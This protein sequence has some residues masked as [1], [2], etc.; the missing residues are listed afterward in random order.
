MSRNA[1]S[2]AVVAVALVC[3]AAAQSA[4]EPARGSGIV[5]GRVVD[6]NGAPVPAA[7]VSLEKASGGDEEEGDRVLTDDS[8]RFVFSNVPAGNFRIDARKAGWLAGSLGRKRPGGSR[9]SFDLSDGERRN[10][11]AITLWRSAII[12]GRVVDDAGDPL[13]G[14]EVRAIKQVFVAGR[15]QNDKPIRE[16]TDDRGVYRFPNLVPGDYLVA[17]IASVLSEPPGLAGAVHAG[18]ELP[19]SYLETMAATGSYPV[20]FDRATGLVG[21]DRA[22]VGSLTS[23]P[24]MPS[25]DGAWPAYPTTYHPGATAQAGATLIRAQSGE[26]RTD[27][28]VTVRLTPTWPV[29]GIVRDAA[30]PAVFHAVHLVPADTSDRPL[31]DVATAVTD[32]KGA[33][34]LYGVPA[35]RYIARVIRV[36]VPTGSRYGLVGGTGEIPQV[37]AF[38]EGPPG[39][40]GPPTESLWHADQSVVVV[41]RAIRDVA[42]TMREGARVRGR[43]RFEGSRAQPTAEEWQKARLSLLPANGRVDAVPWNAPFMNDGRF[44]SAS[45]WPGR[46]LV[47]ADAPPG[48]Y[49]K[50][51]TYQGREISARP[52]DVA[53][54]LDNVVITFTDKQ[55]TMKGSVQVEPGASSEDATVLLFPV[56]SALWIDSGRPSRLMASARV[57]KSA[58]YELKLPPPGEY[59]IVAIPEEAA[60]EWQNPA[61]LSKL[62]T[63]A[64]RIRVTG[65]APMVQSLPLKRVR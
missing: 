9:A 62:A 53:A 19:S 6:A 16:R 12:S 21:P 38:S 48:W 44:V 43:V 2:I 20:L 47:R 59:F 54:D 51:A 8:G 14:A 15:R 27:I 64:E 35:G 1:P 22:L 46:Y 11:F 24:G 63:M 3:A 31:V 52:I 45:I 30:G 56:D 58:Q 23:L 65:D 41:D 32:A 57:A 26:P 55:H 13:I 39:S 17:V 34:T 36:P 25:A 42:I 28:D 37:M 4:Q 5:A 33:F 40:A 61:L 50:D 10:D 49:F 18:Q 29:S 60:D 7:T